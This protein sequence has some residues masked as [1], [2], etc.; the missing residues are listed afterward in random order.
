MQYNQL[1]SL[2]QKWEKEITKHTEKTEE[3]T[4]DFTSF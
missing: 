1:L 3:R 2:R 4:L